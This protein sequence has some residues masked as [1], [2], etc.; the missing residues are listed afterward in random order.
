MLIAVSAY[1]ALT[2]LFR[3]CLYLE[4]TTTPRH[5]WSSARILAILLAIV[6]PGLLLVT[7]VAHFSVWSDPTQNMTA[8]PQKPVAVQSAHR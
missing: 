6:W 4:G 5:G 2:I 3:G 8:T 1:F 7:L